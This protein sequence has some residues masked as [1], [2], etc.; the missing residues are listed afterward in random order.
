VERRNSGDLVDL[1]DV[2]VN[3]KIGDIDN[4]GRPAGHGAEGRGW[5][6]GGLG[7]RDGSVSR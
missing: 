4:F 3:D 5:P 1:V 2:F 7:R 6:E